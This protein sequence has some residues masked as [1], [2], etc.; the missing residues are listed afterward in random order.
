MAFTD[1]HHYKDV[2]LLENNFY[3]PLGFLAEPALADVE[4]AFSSGKFN[5]QNELFAAATGLEGETV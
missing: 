4:F 5:F 2:H 1:V 3:L